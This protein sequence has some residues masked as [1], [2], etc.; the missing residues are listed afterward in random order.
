MALRL[1]IA[2]EGGGM[3]CAA[4]A[5]ALMTLIQ[6]GIQPSCY[7]GCG[8][9]ALIATLAAGGELSER[10]LRPFYAAA[11]YHASLRNVRLNRCLRNQF[12]NLILRDMPSLAMPT[13][14][15]ET[16]VVQ[17]LASVLPMRSDPR[18]WS[19]QALLSSAVRAAMATPGVLPPIN[20]RSRMLMGGGQL[21]ATLPAILHAMGADVS[22]CIRVLDAGCALHE[23]NSAALAVCAHAMV[24]A[25]PHHY[26]LLMTMGNF[27][28]GH[29]VL[30]RQDVQALYD[31]GRIAA[32]KMIPCVKAIT[33]Q[34]GAKI[35]QFPGMTQM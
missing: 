24:A 31:M 29:G 7:A 15:L 20:W 22:I 11:S 25:P 10:A 5:S 8:A 14:D 1:G 28:K 23:T 18:P 6:A 13:M 32:Q 3:R 16:G 9:G 27:E 2:L 35:L 30:G 26:D 21:R 12:G 34:L 19:R 33:G 17:V 4:Q